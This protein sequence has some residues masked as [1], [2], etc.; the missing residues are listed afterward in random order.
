MSTQNAGTGDG[1]QDWEIRPAG[2]W[3]EYAEGRTR[4]L[5]LLA[6]QSES[7]RADRRLS[8]RAAGRY[9]RPEAG[10]GGGALSRWD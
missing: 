3:R 8:A 5:A 4:Y 2:G 6:A 10:R 7:W 9:A 1:H